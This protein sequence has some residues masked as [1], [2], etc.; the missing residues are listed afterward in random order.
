MAINTPHPALST[1]QDRCV[2]RSTVDSR[3]QARN[4]PPNF[5]RL[6]RLYRWMELVTFGPWLGWCRCCFLKEMA[7]SRRALVLGD[8]DGRFTAR[9][10]QTSATVRTDAVDASPAMLRALV[11]HAGRHHDRVRTHLADLRKL[12]PA[13]LIGDPRRNLPYDLV[14]THFFLD[15]LTSSEVRTLATT[16]RGA[17]SPHARWVVS[18]F[19][20]PESWFGRLIARPVVWGLYCAFGWLTGLSVRR[21]PDYAAA[22]RE[23]GFS[24]EMRR[25]W[26]GGLLTS[27]LWAVTQAGSVPDSSVTRL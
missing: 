6:A 22:L 11:R 21:L 12:R 9:L 4:V 25:A 14:V 5:D 7:S 27:E 15:C 16:L 10:L 3:D 8:G 13:S 20:I 19:A 1:D 23:A 26:L 2:P 18:E 17:V 24:L